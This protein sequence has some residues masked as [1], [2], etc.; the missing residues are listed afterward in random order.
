M[1]RRRKTPRASGAARREPRGR[2][3]AA[4]ETL[5][6][7]RAGEVDAVVGTGGKH[8]ITLAGVDL[9]YRLLFDHMSEGA[10]TLTDGGIIAYCNR[11]LAA[12]VRMPLGRVTGTP[13]RQFVPREERAA[14]DALVAAGLRR[15]TSGEHTLLSPGGRA[16]PVALSFAPLRRAGSADAIGTIGVVTDLTARELAEEARR[17][18]IRQATTTVEEDRRRIARELHDETGQSLTALLVGLQAI[19]DARTLGGASGVARRLR[20][21]AAQTLDEVGR[22]SRAMHPGILEDVGLAAAATRHAHEFGK[23]HAIAVHVHMEGLD[24]EALPPAVQSTLY[25]A[26]Q[27][28]LTNVAKH[29]AART[30]Q[31]YLTRHATA[32]ELVVRDDGAGATLAALTRGRRLGLRVMRERA[33]LLGGSVSVA[34]QLGA[35]TTIAARY[36]LGKRAPTPPGRRPAATRAPR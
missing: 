7:I 36:P 34:S 32:V 29:A 11:R 16:V 5:R 4:E 30:V 6:A 9:A 8:V 2:L 22:I 18:L 35:G 3:Q 23:L 13:L 27:E 31:I 15:R 28:A 12:L 21:I 10:V 14:F 25:R 26:L 33:A 20:A 19:E 1:T 24:D 17:R